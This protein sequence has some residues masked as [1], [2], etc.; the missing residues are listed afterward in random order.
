M[1]ERVFYYTSLDQEKIK[2]Q[3]MISQSGL[4]FV[5]RGASVVNLKWEDKVTN[6]EEFQHAAQQ[7]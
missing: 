6:S 7:L 3:S 2:I 1:R 4:A 5:C